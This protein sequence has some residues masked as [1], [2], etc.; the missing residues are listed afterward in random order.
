VNSTLRISGLD[1][2]CD[3]NLGG[4]GCTVTASQ[5]RSLYRLLLLGQSIQGA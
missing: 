4:G 5:I 2:Q 1:L 3:R